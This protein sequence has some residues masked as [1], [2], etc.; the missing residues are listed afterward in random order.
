MAKLTAPAETAAALRVSERMLLFCVA[1]NTDWKHTA[2]PGE[3]VTTMV[4]KG[5]VERDTG[6]HLAL[7][8]RGRAVLR[9]MLP[10]ARRRPTPRS[11]PRKVPGI[12]EGPP[13]VAEPGVCDPGDSIKQ[14]P[15]G[16]RGVG[17]HDHSRVLPAY[18]IMRLNVR[19]TRGSTG[20]AV[21]GT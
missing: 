9:A 5:L 11:R 1:S 17:C 3:I 20:D 19:L 4:V 18:E 7:T 12:E 13:P 16:R 14:R 8:D 10:D 2:I 6:G 21:F 15:P